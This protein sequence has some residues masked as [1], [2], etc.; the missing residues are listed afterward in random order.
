MSVL[1]CRIAY[2]MIKDAEEKGL[3]TPGKVGIK[4]SS[5]HRFRR[6]EPQPTLPASP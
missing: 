5:L 1:T 4:K 2:S 6:I 3:I